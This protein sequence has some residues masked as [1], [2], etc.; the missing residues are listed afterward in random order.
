MVIGVSTNGQANWNVIMKS[1][2]PGTPT[3]NKKDVGFKDL[4]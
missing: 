1:Q 3:N 2:K 4:K